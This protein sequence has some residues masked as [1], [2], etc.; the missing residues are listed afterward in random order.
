MD[1]LKSRNIP[2][3]TIKE[4]SDF[5]LEKKEKKKEHAWTLTT[6]NEHECGKTEIEETND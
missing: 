1:T 3:L 6:E 4:Y 5:S 2:V